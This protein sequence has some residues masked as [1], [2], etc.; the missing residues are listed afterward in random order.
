M[1]PEQIVARAREIMGI[2]EAAIARAREHLGPPFAD[3]IRRILAIEG[4]VIVCGVGKSGIIGE[5]IAATLSSTGTPAIFLKPLDAVHGDLGVVRGEDLLIGI[6]ASGETEELLN[7]VLAAKRIGVPIAALTG[8][9]DS[10]LAREADVTIDASIEREACPLGLAPTA[11]TTLALAI[12]DALAMVLLE[13][14]AFTREDYA[15]THPGGSLGRRLRLRVRDLMRTGDLVPVV[16]AKAPLREALRA[17]TEIENL[18]LTLVRDGDGCLAGILTDGD[19]RRILRRDGTPADLLDR[20]VAAF[21]KPAPIT[22]DEDAFASEALRIMEVRGITSLAIADSRGRPRGV[23]HLHDILG[24][25][26][27]VV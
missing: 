2:E 7:V 9:A 15:R 3:L 14:R 18:G 26:K 27:V 6:S 25:G 8:V 5:K 20:P 4:R 16:D 23:I 19:L 13:E 11:S 22:V 1:K 21:M 10:T 24:R 12:G 17:M